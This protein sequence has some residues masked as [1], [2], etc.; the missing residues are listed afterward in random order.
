VRTSPSADK[1]TLYGYRVELTSGADG[2]ITVT[3]RSV[4]QSSQ[5]IYFQG[6]LP[7]GSAANNWVSLFIITYQDQIAFFANGKLIGSASRLK[8][9]SGTLALGVQPGTQADFSNLVLR[10]VTPE[11]R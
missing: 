11:T 5:V 7:E 1:K 3:A 2:K 9:L 6:P 10:D 4:L 8:L